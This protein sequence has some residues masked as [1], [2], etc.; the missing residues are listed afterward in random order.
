MLQHARVRGQ[1]HPTSRRSS[2]ASCPRLR[3]RFLLCFSLAALLLRLLLVQ[4]L[5]LLLLQLLLVGLDP[6]HGVP[7]EL[8]VCLRPR[9][10]AA[11][12]T[13][14][15]WPNKGPA[16]VCAEASWA[17]VRVCPGG[18]G[19]RD[20]VGVELQLGNRAGGG[21]GAAGQPCE[22]REERG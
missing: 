19:L 18:E 16:A 6:R 3:L 5:L 1:Q 4:R 17:V 20:H 8:R 11:S 21:Q 7:K 22:G 12:R 2:T 14:V 9:G 10:V 15:A 13:P